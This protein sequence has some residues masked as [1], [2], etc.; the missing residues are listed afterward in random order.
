MNPAL[1]EIL[2]CPETHQPL[3]EAEALLLEEL[4]AAI[5]AGDLK[6]RAG[7]KVEEPLDGGLV[8]R[9]GAFVYPV[10]LGIP[11]MLIDEAIPLGPKR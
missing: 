9:D 10:R 2:C 11:V 3:R 6:N 8:R 1:L 7:K 5:R 4:N